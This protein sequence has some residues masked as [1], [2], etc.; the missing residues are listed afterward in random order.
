MLKTNCKKAKENLRNY[1][2]ESSIDYLTENYGFSVTEENIYSIIKD[3]YRIET[4]SNSQKRYVMD[5]ETWSQGLPCGGLF[6][7]YLSSA[8]DTLANILEETEDERNRYSEAEAETML[9]RL[10]YRETLKA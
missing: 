4:Y 3:V 8:V 9:T 7:Y 5:F 2:L 6:D 10:I 1:C